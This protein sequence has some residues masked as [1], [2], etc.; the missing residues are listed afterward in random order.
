M[1][2]YDEMLAATPLDELRELRSAVRTIYQ[3]AC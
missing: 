3:D 2:Q 1:I